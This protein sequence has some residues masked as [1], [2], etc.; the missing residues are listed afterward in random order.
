MHCKLQRLGCVSPTP[1]PG[2]W[3]R[4]C[5]SEMGH[6]DEV[7]GVKGEHQL[8][9]FSAELSEQL[10]GSPDVI[11]P[12]N[13][14]HK[15]K[16]KV[17]N[18]R[19]MIDSE[20]TLK[21]ATHLSK[22]KQKKLAQIADRKA[23][24]AR[25]EGVLASLAATRLTD[26]ERMLLQRT[27]RLGKSESKKE[28]LLHVVAAAQL[29]LKPTER[30]L[31]MALSHDNIMAGVDEALGLYPGKALEYIKYAVTGGGAA[32]AAD[33]RDDGNNH[34]QS[35]QPLNMEKYGRERRKR[36]RTTTASSQLQC[37]E[38]TA[39]SK[40][41]PPPPNH[42]KAL[43]SSICSSSGS[44]SQKGTYLDDHSGND[45]PDSVERIMPDVNPGSM[46]VVH[47]T[48]DGDTALND[49]VNNISTT[50]ASHG[51]LPSQ[52]DT[53]S[54]TCTPS[55]W[56][57]KMNTGL[58]SI[59]Q[60][61]DNTGKAAATSTNEKAMMGSPCTND[62]LSKSKENGN[63]SVSHEG[64]VKYVPIETPL[65]TPA[66]AAGSIEKKG[67]AGKKHSVMRHGGHSWYVHRSADVE[68]QRMALPIC[69]MEQEVVEA[70]TLSDIVILCGETGCGK[71]TQVP[72]FA[73]EAGFA[74]N[75]LII[76]VT[77]PR[78]VAAVST[79][80]RVAHEMN[81]QCGKGG[82]V[83]YQVRY[84]SSGVTSD[85]RIKFMTDGILLKELSADILLKSYSVIV[86]DEAHERGLNTDVLLGMLSR[87]VPLRRKLADEQRKRYDATENDEAR[88]LITPPMHPLKVV[89]M[90]A[91]LQTAELA[92]NSVLFPAPPPVVSVESR[93]YPVT[94]HFSKHTE[95]RDYS[96]AVFKK[97]C[98]IHRQLPAGG[99]LVFLTGRLETLHLCSLLNR[100]FNHDGEDTRRSDSDLDPALVTATLVKNP[101][102]RNTHDML[103]R[104]ADDD[105]EDA[106]YM[107]DNS[108]SVDY[109]CPDLFQK[110]GEL[111][112]NQ[113][114]AGPLHVLPLYAM[115][116]PDE[117][118]K[119]FVP[120]PAGHRLVVIATNVAETSITI[121]GIA[122]VV[123]CG[124][125]KQRRIIGGSQINAFEVDW[126]SQASADQR[127]GRA[128]RM[129][130][131]HCY[132]LYSSAVY[133]RQFP[134]CTA[135]DVETQPL[136]NV[137]L[138]MLAM[139]IPSIGRF[140]FPT[141]PDPYRLRIAESMLRNLG[142]IQSEKRKVSGSS[143]NVGLTQVKED[144]WK[145]T[146]MGRAM[147][148][149]PI[150]V[151]LSR[152]LVMAK[153]AGL[154]EHAIAM[155]SLMEE[156]DP[157]TTSSG[158][159]NM[160]R[161][162]E[163]SHPESDA[164]T[165]LWVAGAYAFARLTD[166]LRG[167]SRFCEMH[168]LHEPTMIRSFSLRNQITRIVNLSF[169]RNSKRN[170]LVVRS[171]MPLPTKTEVCV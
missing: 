134:K 119:V 39:K 54:S 166:R 45:S 63:E 94:I 93:Q 147:A 153:Q 121:P 9:L 32:A 44:L 36:S 168:D 22:S 160:K 5:R 56:A 111:P 141:P 99:V 10:E 42:R 91:T 88:R 28:C 137:I 123:D 64:K 38:G 53:S 100:E 135:P 142:V 52:P 102:E 159:T 145:L 71:S 163:F 95:L 13:K 12:A 85:T 118:S 83:A 105:E 149:L 143:I 41:Q 84:D 16:K 23:K 114:N 80:E 1:C 49:N 170:P 171:S 152:M 47:N 104:E 126:I 2:V 55:S 27:S 19:M 128:G 151:R 30:E 18:G 127:A 146:H 51:R 40:W 140:P 120:P 109:T 101:R 58:M 116:S 24:A 96:R 86:L 92:G 89:I 122:Y 73:Y 74:K 76:G 25:R 164:L 155:V 150:G 68:T 46:V 31:N 108:A 48:E 21:F 3:L 136:E 113:E 8:G 124:R 26:D 62:D 69:G 34:H 158:Y 98:Q 125:S 82:I 117:Q 4:Y 106:E 115:L 72:Q 103:F 50:T 161:R 75:G 156:Q 87:S 20:E 165:R 81:T 33:G 66:A 157:F 14:K 6:N 70:M 144:C 37:I 17:G 139:G 169:G 65:I 61:R 138:H 112:L 162:M 129:G 97:V 29:G 79:A 167:G 57:E 90:S 110:E 107:S 11:I 130:P 67:V 15:K 148:L 35:T 77:Q 131:G 133:E 7:S 43:E 59:C 60:R 78:R 154:L 132:R